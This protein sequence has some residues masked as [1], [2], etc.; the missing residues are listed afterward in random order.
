MNFIIIFKYLI[1]QR[2]R[3]KMQELDEFDNIET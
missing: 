1:I 3:I 2:V